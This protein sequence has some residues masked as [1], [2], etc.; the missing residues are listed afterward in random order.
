MR[1]PSFSENFSVKILACTLQGK[2]FK[3]HPFKGQGWDQ[4]IT[5]CGSLFPL[6]ATTSLEWL[7][8]FSYFSLKKLLKK[9]ARD[10]RACERIH[11]TSLWP[12]TRW[13][14]FGISKM[15][16]PQLVKFWQQQFINIYCTI[17]VLWV[18]DKH[19]WWKG[20]QS[21]TPKAFTGQCYDIL[22]QSS[23]L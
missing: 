19:L 2:I 21:M 4:G 14:Y 15:F 11:S 23:D 10:S 18:F 20:Q 13:K 5:L 17:Q 16:W 1:D 6:T 12:R 7:R 22:S 8:K 9:V 3:E